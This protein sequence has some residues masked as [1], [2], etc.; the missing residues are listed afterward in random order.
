MIWRI[1]M[2]IKEKNK[3]QVRGAVLIIFLLGF[4]AGLLALN[5]YHGLS[6]DNP[7]RRDGETRLQQTF[8]RLGMTE[9]QQAEARTIFNEARTQMQEMRKENASRRK[10]VRRQTDERL[11]KVLTPEQWQEFQEIRADAAGARRDRRQADRE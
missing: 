2:D 7:P 5:A 4:V 3:W 6:A 11:Q 8:E 10:E 1:E 9:A